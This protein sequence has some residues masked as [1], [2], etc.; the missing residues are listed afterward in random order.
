MW[1]GFFFFWR[2]GVLFF[3]NVNILLLNIRKLVYAEQENYYIIT[4]FIDFGASDKCNEHLGELHKLVYY[5]DTLYCFRLIR[6]ENS[7]F[8]LSFQVDLLVERHD[9]LQKSMKLLVVL[10]ALT[11]LLLVMFILYT[12]LYSGSN[13]PAVIEAQSNS[14]ADRYCS[15]D[16]F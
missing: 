13:P 6:W 15:G 12:S 11:I 2:G 5:R 10:Q 9:A 8:I 16:L 7:C 3:T 4:D 14:T 1:F